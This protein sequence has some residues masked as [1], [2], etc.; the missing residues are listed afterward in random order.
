[1]DGYCRNQKIRNLLFVLL[2]DVRLSVFGVCLFVYKNIKLG[3]KATRIFLL[4]F[5]NIIKNNLW[6]MIYQFVYLCQW[7][8]VFTPS[9]CLFVDFLIHK[10]FNKGLYNIYL[11]LRWPVTARADYNRTSTA[12]SPRISRRQCTLIGG[13]WKLS[14]PWDI[15]QRNFAYMQLIFT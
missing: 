4:I 15:N 14:W 1:M 7:D 9:P 5:E 6:K 3:I 12:V 13:D 10:I 2:I 11:T 8:Y